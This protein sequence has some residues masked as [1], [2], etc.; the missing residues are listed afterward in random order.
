MPIYEYE[1]EKCGQRFELRRAVIDD[2]NFVKCPRCGGKHLRKV[3]SSFG[4]TSSGKGC[5]P[6]GIKGGG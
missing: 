4:I 1:C 5:A 6:S 2:N 3:Y